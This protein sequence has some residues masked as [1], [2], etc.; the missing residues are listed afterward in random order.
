MSWFLILPIP[1]WS[2]QNPFLVTNAGN[3]KDK[4]L[5]TQKPDGE[6]VSRH[7]ADLTAKLKACKRPR[8]DARNF[9]QESFR[10]G[11]MDLEAFILY[12]VGRPSPMRSLQFFATPTVRALITSLRIARQ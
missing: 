6:P 4:P 10:S 3:A 7:H 8:T 12:L 9:S 2:R 11:S 1:R 5:E